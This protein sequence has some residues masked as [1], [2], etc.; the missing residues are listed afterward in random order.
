MILG[1]E[2]LINDTVRWNKTIFNWKNGIK[3]VHDLQ[4]RSELN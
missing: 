3:T 2:N 1:T 4:S